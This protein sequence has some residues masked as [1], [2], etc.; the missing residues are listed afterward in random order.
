MPI[1]DKLERKFGWIAIPGIVRIL[2]GFQLLTFFLIKLVN[3][4]ILELLILD[5]GAI[6]QGEVWRLVSFTI[7]PPAY[8]P[9]LLVFAL[10]FMMFMGEILESAWGSFR[11]TLYIAGG[12][13]G[14]VAGAFLA[15]FA[16]GELGWFEFM[17]RTRST[18]FI[19]VTTILCAAAVMQ[20]H[21]QINLFGVIP[22]KLYWI[23]LFDGGL[24][25]IDFLQ[26]MRLHPL[27]GASLL[28]AI[29]NFL[30][31]FGPSS[32][33]QMRQRGEVAARR[34]KFEGAKMPEDESLHRCATCGKSEHDDADLEFRVAADGEEYCEEHLPGRVSD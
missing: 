15:Y 1:A 18:G 4:E 14:I 33:R 5:P 30:I 7:L 26:L 24:V 22:I 13:L 29:S 21:L 32:Y 3:D 34:R 19:W 23:A 2:A 27:L 28:L 25:L 9:L 16:V 11:L 12:V 31:V 17:F 10:F 20:P 8:S 6:L